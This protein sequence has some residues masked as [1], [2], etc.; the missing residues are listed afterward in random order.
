MNNTVHKGRIFRV[1]TFVH[2]P[3][4]K[5]KP[6]PVRGSLR[7]PLCCIGHFRERLTKYVHRSCSKTIFNPAHMTRFH[8]PGLSLH[9][10]LDLLFFSS[11][12]SFCS[13]V[14]ASVANEE[15]A[16]Q[17][18][19]SS[20]FNLSHS[21]WSTL[22]KT[23]TQLSF[24]EEESSNSGEVSNS[25]FHFKTRAENGR[26]NSVTALSPSTLKSVSPFKSFC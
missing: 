26:V 22:D 12:F 11:L 4:H 6:H 19:F 21:T 18:S 3:F 24:E 13:D 20:F 17:S 15:S 25:S 23:A 7:I 8:R 2:F 14:E 16:C 5:R 1:T 9:A 10:D